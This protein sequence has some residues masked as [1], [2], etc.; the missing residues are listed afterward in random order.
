MRHTIT[1]VP[2]KELHP[3]ILVLPATFLCEGFVW[4]GSLF[5]KSAQA[6]VTL[7]HWNSA[8]TRSID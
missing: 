8:L 5:A 2:A 6:S 1:H 7:F 4:V 3:A